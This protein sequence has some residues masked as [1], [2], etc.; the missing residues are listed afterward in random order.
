MKAGGAIGKLATVTQRKAGT[1]VPF[2]DDTLGVSFAAPADWVIQRQSGERK[3]K[4][5]IHL[6]DP[7]ADADHVILQLKPTESLS[8]TERQSARAWA[9]TDFRENHAKKRENFKLRADSWNNRV[10]AGRPG[11]SCLADFTESGKPKTALAL[12]ALGPKTCE[13]FVLVCP[14]DKLD[15]IRPAFESIVASYRM[16]K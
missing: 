1:P 15:A 16:T 7:A 4:V 3:G 5:T 14:P 12:Y 11:V 10:I 13:H 9:E 8:A 6:L 2:R